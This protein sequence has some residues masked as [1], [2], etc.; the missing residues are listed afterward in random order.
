MTQLQTTESKG[1][2]VAPSSVDL[3]SLMTSQPVEKEDIKVSKL[4]ITQAS[5]DFFKDGR[6]SVGEIRGSTECNL[7]AALGEEVEFIPFFCWKTWVTVKEKGGVFLAEAPQTIGAPKRPREETT[8]VSKLDG[9]LPAHADLGVT[10]VKHYEQLN[11]YCLLPKDIAEGVY[12]PVVVSFKSTS[13]KAGAVIESKRALLEEFGKPVCV[14]TFKLGAKED[15]NPD[16]QAYFMYTVAESRNTTDLELE[17]VQRW[18]S[19]FK[20]ATVTVDDPEAKPSKN[21]TTKKRT[22]VA[23][24][25]EY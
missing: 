19:K 7:V 8:D 24:N 18:A 5:S 9:L 17:A 10:A 25:E 11:Y 23:D 20:T 1:V 3:S 6:A 13:Y 16:G 22:T 21:K 12:M 4:L 15:K 2:L 14:K